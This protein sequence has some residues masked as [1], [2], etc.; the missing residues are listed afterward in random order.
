MKQATTKHDI[1]RKRIIKAARTAIRLK[2]SLAADAEM[3]QRLPAI[4]K[5]LE[6]A[7][8]KGKAVKISVAHLLDA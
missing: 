7:L 8:L 5:Q 3:A 6:D 2:H 1:E 4:E